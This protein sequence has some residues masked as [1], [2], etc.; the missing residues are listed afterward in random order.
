MRR[1]LTVLQRRVIAR[2]RDAHYESLADAAR[3]AWQRA[4][5]YE[6]TA[7]IREPELMADYHK[8]NSQLLTGFM[9]RRDNH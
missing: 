8:A 1:Q 5:S 3:E 7:P 6:P 2:L 4:E 9:D